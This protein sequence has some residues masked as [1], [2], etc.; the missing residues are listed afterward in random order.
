M[1]FFSF[2]AAAFFSAPPACEVLAF[3]VFF[4]DVEATIVATWMFCGK[5]Q[6]CGA[7]RV[8]HDNHYVSSLCKV[9]RVLVETRVLAKVGDVA[10]YKGVGHWE[11]ER[12]FCMFVSL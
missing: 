10:G 2:A 3:R 11:K 12:C 4:E 7:T 9:T 6:N 5:R 8:K 1:D